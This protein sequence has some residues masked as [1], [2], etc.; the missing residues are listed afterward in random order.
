[1]LVKLKTDATQMTSAKVFT[2]QTMN[3]EC[4]TV[5]RVMALK[6]AVV[7]THTISQ[8]LTTRNEPATKNASV[9]QLSWS[10]LTEPSIAWHTT[11]TRWRKIDAPSSE[12]HTRRLTYI[13]V[14]VFQLEFK[15]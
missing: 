11:L 13:R 5:F 2:V 6:H 4:A 9:S 12:K 15:S 10:G 14:N 1:V 8:T 7:R 3:R